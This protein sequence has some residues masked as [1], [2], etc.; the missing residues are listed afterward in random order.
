MLYQRII[1][2]TVALAVTLVVMIKGRQPAKPVGLTALSVSSTS[3]VAVQISGDVAHPGVY[4]V[5]DTNLTNSVILVADPLCLGELAIRSD[6]LSAPVQTGKTLHL[7]C[8]GP[9]NRAIIQ[10]GTMKSSQLLTLG[11][12]LDLNQVTE[13]DLDLLPGIG[14]SLARRIIEI[15]QKNG[16]FKSA[17][18]LLQVE[19]IGNKKLKQ[20]SRYFK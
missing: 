9:D 4:M 1:L 11:L 10:Y 5:C 12:P 19:G 14:P 20:L 3:P 15:R 7:L 8:K 2:V 16:Y 17:N 18:E 13:A 6:L